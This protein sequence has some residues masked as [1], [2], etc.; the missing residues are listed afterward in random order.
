MSPAP[1][2]WHQR[3]IGY[4][5]YYLLTYVKF[6]GVGEVFISPLDVELAPNNVVQPDVLVIL[7]EHLDRVTDSRIIGSPDLV[8]EVASPSTAIYDRR[9]KCDMYARAG[10]PEYWIADPVARTVEMLVL[11]DGTYFSL[12]YY[13][14]SET[15]PSIIV[16]TIAAVPVEKFF[17]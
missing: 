9:E 10:V 8:V 11:D 16:P 5:H 14:G 3:A 2:S 6:T 7:Q 12:G 1:T 15:L 4:F 17:A 13:E